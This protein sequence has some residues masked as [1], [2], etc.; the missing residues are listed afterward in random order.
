MTV[1]DFG[2]QIMNHEK[3]LMSYSS[4]FT[5]EYEDRQDLVQETIIKALSNRTKFK[6]GTNLRGWLC[7][8]MA[9]TFIN[10]YHRRVKLENYR[11]NKADL[12]K[13]ATFERH[14]YE[15]PEMTTRMNEVESLINK[16]SEDLKVVLKM[17]LEG[18][19]YREIAEELDYPI[20]T[21]KHKIFKARDILSNWLSSKSLVE[22]YS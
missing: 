6:R 10:Q 11:S 9:N 20:G 4:R 1:Q 21:V 18:Y 14:S 22:R 12:A 8:I 15:S 13:A 2:Y 19:K 3:T 17:Y 16:L 7:T 5:L